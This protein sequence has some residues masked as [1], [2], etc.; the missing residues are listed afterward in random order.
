MESTI[1]LNINGNYLKL[2]IMTD[3]EVFKKAIE[4]AIENGMKP[5]ER[6][7]KK[8]EGRWVVPKD[9]GVNDMNI[10][11]SHEFAKAFWGE[12]PYRGWVR[13]YDKDYVVD[14]KVLPEFEETPIKE[15]QYHL[16]K[17]VLCENPIDYLRKFIDNTENSESK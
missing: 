11:F 2:L 4:I 15:W 13:F 14:K 17:M 16:Q 5:L 8:V 10:I 9:K 6:D 12:E 3:K 7:T 1:D